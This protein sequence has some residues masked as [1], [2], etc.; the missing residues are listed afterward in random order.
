MPI[1]IK[2]LIIRTT[3]VDASTAPG[4]QPKGVSPKEMER[5][6]K[7]IIRECMDKVSRLLEKKI[8]R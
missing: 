6:K 3:L 7:E 8:Q 4:D 1:E 2:E 5:L